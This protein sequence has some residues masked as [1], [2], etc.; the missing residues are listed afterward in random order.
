YIPGERLRLEA[1][2][3]LAA[4]TSQEAVQAVRTELLDRYGPM[5]VP[6]ESLLAVA[7]FR[8]LA[9]SYGVGEVSLQGSVVRVSPVVLRESQQLRLQRLYP[10]S[11]YKN[12]VQTISVPRPG[13]PGAPLRDQALLEW[14]RE[15]LT[16]VLGQ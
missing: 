16:S 7:R 12:A 2:R 10:R 4:A 6:V 11:V 1:Y 3:A 13:Q 9:R 5:P 15:L 8:A 14:T